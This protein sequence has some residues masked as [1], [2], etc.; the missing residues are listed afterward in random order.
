M[1]LSSENWVSGQRQVTEVQQT[2]ADK[3]ESALKSLINQKLT[4]G[5]RR[6]G[7]LTQKG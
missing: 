1:G 5:V 6:R 7:A 2:T 4:A 3:G